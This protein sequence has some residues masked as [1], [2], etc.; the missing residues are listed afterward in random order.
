M[1]TPKETYHKLLNYGTKF[2][3]LD[4]KYFASGGF[5]NGSGQFVNGLLSFLLVIAFANLLPKETYGLYRYILSIAGILNIFTLT[6]MNQ[7]VLQAVS[8]GN[9]GALKTSVKYQL[10]WNLMMLSA[11]WIL[12]AYYFLNGNQTFAVSF[13]ILGVFSPLI[14]ALNTY[15]A[16]LAGKKEFR[17][18]NI[19]SVISTSIY[20]ASII[21]AI[22]LSNGVV[23]LVV[24]FSLA[25]FAANLIFYIATLRIF[26]PP[27]AAPA[28]GV[29]KY[30]REL[31]FIGF[32]GPIVSQIDSIILNHF[33]GPIQ[34]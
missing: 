9:E 34:L 16:Y 26:K 2:L 8:T 6:G 32:I 25:T 21:T 13:F 20:A 15:G 29:L 10:K 31:T 1:P 14:A 27:A 3:G 7:A 5:W 11:F 30:G 19:F 17:L 22:I 24:A 18:N 4:L 28:G 33:W 23:G 12:G